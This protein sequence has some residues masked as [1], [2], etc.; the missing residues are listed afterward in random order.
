MAE[1]NAKSL[2]RSSLY[3]G[4]AQIWRI[5]SRFV[6]TP[7]I[8]AKLGLEGYG[9]WTLL[10]GICAYV[11]MF[12][13][14]FGFAYSKFSA[15]Y[16]R[17]KDYGRLAEII[18]SGI[19]L[20]G[21]VAFLAL[22]A[23]WLLRMPI[24]RVLNVPQGLLDDAGWALLIVA[25]CLLLRMSFGC[26][27]QVLAGLQRMD[28]Q[29]KMTILA[30]ALDFVVALFLL[31]GG[32]GLLALAGGHFC[33]Q[34]VATGVAWILCRRLCPGLRISPF[35]ASR[36]GL[37]QVVSLGGRFQLLSFLNTGIQEGL[38]MLISGLCGVSVLAVFELASKLLNLGRSMS[39]S[40]IAPLMPAFANLHSGGDIDRWR[41]LY[42]QSSK[43][44]ALAAVVSLVGLVVLADRLIVVWTGNEYP[45]ATWTIRAL[46]TAHFLS[47][48]TGVAT[49]GLRG[50][51]TIRLELTY[52]IISSTITVVSI[53]P[54]YLWLG[55]E[56]MVLTVLASQVVGSTWFLVVF[57]GQEGIGFARYLREILIR[58]AAIGAVAAA[59]GFFLWPSTAGLVPAWPERWRAVFEV[60]VW[61]SVFASALGT[62]LWFTVLTATE[63]RYLIQRIISR[64]GGPRPTSDA[65]RS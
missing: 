33:G 22:S 49:A 63:R 43:I 48:M 14:S 54:A 34:V 46:A 26:V 45:L 30:S 62:A 53:V 12:N 47:L 15:E 65:M 39:G 28:L 38:K 5:G 51:G 7:I 19:A 29:H 56:G 37:R 60:A 55:Y 36:W 20:I 10:F 58:S 27:F 25:V 6:L 24:L 17:K 41:S 35:R 21:G 2:A 11:S 59:L 64:S 44:V 32:H 50:R 8:I 52:A 23:L 3:A 9:T 1:V 40:L 57:A 16:D 13:T 42:V 4:L 18:G 61:G 31:L